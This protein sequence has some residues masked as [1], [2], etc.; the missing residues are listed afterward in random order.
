MNINED[1]V[2]EIFQELCNQL[3]KITRGEL[4]DGAYK[5]LERRAEFHESEERR[6]KEKLSIT[7][8]ELKQEEVYREI[9]LK[10]NRATAKAEAYKRAKQGI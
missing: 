3:E 7:F 5:I 4:K 10:K 6:A 8:N 1:R 9:N 2:E